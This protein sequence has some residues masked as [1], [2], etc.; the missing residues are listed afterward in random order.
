MGKKG[1]TIKYKDD[2]KCSNQIESKDI[3]VVNRFSFF[4]MKSTSSQEICPKLALDRRTDKVLE[5]I[6]RCYDMSVPTNN[7]S[8]ETMVSFPVI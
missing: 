4:K 3:E 7:R 8:G 1:P 5:K 6:F 2:K